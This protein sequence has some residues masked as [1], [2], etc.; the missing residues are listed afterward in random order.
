MVLGLLLYEAVDL[1]W[2]FGGMTY[3]GS[4]YVYNWYYH[5]PTPDDIEIHELKKLNNRIAHLENLIKNNHIKA[6]DDHEIIS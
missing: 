3:R 2:N 1:F 5:I 6:L 4:K